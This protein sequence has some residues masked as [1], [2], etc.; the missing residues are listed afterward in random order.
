VRP[1]RELPPP[2]LP[3]VSPKN[4]SVMLRPEPEW[5]DVRSDPR[6]DEP[7]EARSG[8]RRDERFG[9]PACAGMADEPPPF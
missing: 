1:P 7:H 2:A 4:F 5:G 8:E 3:K 9:A 6:R